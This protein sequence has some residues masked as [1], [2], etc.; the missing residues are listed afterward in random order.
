[1]GSGSVHA[2]ELLGSLLNRRGLVHRVLNARQ[3]QEE[4]QIIALA[5][6]PGQITIAT[7]MAGRGT[8]IKLGPGVAELGGLYMIST[9]CHEEYRV[10][11]QLYG[12][13]ARQGDPGSCETHLSLNDGLIQNFYPLRVRRLLGAYLAK[14]RSL[15]P[16]LRRGLVRLPQYFIST[17]HRLERRD[18]MQMSEKLGK[19]LAYSGRQE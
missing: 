7:N 1:M 16:W 11:R 19:M 2:S 9:E 3:N 5:G 17:R 13:C 6:Q 10:D 15:P 4:A 14:G 12:R 18:V 8:D